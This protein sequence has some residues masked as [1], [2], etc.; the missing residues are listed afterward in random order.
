MI[1]PAFSRLATQIASVKRAALSAGLGTVPVTVLTNLPCA[2]LDPVNAE[3]RTRLQLD[4]AYEIWQTAFD[5]AYD[6]RKGDL[7]V[8]A[9]TE[10]PVR[11]VESYTW[12]AGTYL[13]VFVEKVGQ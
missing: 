1:D 8:I 2:P 13:R 10:Y 6:I 9:S 4:A 7:L 5:S 12:R 11:A 3:T